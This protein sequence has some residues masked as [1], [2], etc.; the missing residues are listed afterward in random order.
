M[1][2]DASGRGRSRGSPTPI[3]GEV[4]PLVAVIALGARFL[5]Q[6]VTRVRIA[7]A[8]DAIPREGPVIIAANHVSNADPVVLGSFLTKAL[9]R[10]L[11]WLGKREIFDWPVLGWAA[12]NGGIH[13]VDRDAA[14]VEAFRI[15]SRVLEAGHVLAVFPEGTRSR[16]GGLQVAREGLAMLA[17]RSG[18]PIVP[19]G[20]AGSHRVWPRGRALPRIGGRITMTVGAPFVLAD[21]LAAEAPAEPDADAAPPSAAE[22]RLRRRAA[23][24]RATTILMS[25]IAELLPPDQRGAY[26]DASGGAG[27]PRS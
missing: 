4:T 5:A 16:D 14:D 3:S 17:L 2:A 27:V 21:T 15:A 8:V 10:R 23:T 25:R 7:G 18:A 11:N 1:S 9:G 19:V 20:I 6:A 26:A 13:P 12:T 22:R 24:G